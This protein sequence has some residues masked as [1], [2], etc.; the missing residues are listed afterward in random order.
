MLPELA[1]RN[2]NTMAP[3]SP[4]ASVCQPG[5]DATVLLGAQRPTGIGDTPSQTSRDYT[6]SCGCWGMKQDTSS[7]PGSVSSSHSLNRPFTSPIMPPH[8][9]PPQTPSSP[10]APQTALAVQS[11]WICQSVLGGKFTFQT[12]KS[13][14]RLAA[15]VWKLIKSNSV[16]YFNFLPLPKLIHT[17]LLPSIQYFNPKLQQFLKMSVKHFYYIKVPCFEEP[18]GVEKVSLEMSLNYNFNLFALCDKYIWLY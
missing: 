15:L 4:L 16:L 18:M 9:E 10:A 6:A 14:S 17:R 2:M 11:R 13:V 8:K 7:I 3:R 12:E 5:R 1:T